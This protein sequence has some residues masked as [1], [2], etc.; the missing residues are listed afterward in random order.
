MGKFINACTIFEKTRYLTIFTIIYF[1]CEFL[2]EKSTPTPTR[3]LIG[4]Y[5]NL[6]LIW[7]PS[8]I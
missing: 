7:R 4:T 1:G 5:V 3:A 2:P 8:I 6:D